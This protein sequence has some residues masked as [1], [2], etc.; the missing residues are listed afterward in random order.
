VVV[1]HRLP[2]WTRLIGATNVQGRPLNGSTEPC[3]EPA[4]LA[5]GRFLHVEQAHEGLR[6]LPQNWLKIADALTAIFPAHPT[7]QRRG[8][9]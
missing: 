5:S 2:G 6:D 4:I 9:R 3:N 7:A 8:R 1:A